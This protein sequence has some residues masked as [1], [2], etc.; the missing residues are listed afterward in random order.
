MPNMELNRAGLEKLIGLIPALESH[1]GSWGEPDMQIQDDI[2]SMGVYKYPPVVE[3]LL[4]LIGQA[5][6]QVDFN[7]S[8]WQA[9]AKGYVEDPSLVEKIDF[10]TARMLL[11]LHTRKERFCEG[12]IGSMCACGHIAVVLKRIKQ[13]ME[14]GAINVD[15]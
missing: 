11:T 8:N 6:I 10:E 15:Q 5:G 3:E 14:L 1:T 13:L 9:E 12:H 7:W 2:L 4:F